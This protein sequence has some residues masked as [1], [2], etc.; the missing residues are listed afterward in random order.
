MPLLPVRAVSERRKRRSTLPALRSQSSSSCVPAQH[1]A[2]HV[3]SRCCSVGSVVSNAMTA[4]WRISSIFFA[5]FFLC[6]ISTG[7]GQT[8]EGREL[9]QATLLADVTAVVPGKPFTVGARLRMVPNWHTYW[10]F[11]G[12]AGIPTEIKWK[13]PDGWKAGQIQWPVPLRLVEPGDIQIYGYH[14]EV[15]LLQEITPPP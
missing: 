8:Y 1:T 2:S 9:V 6:A 12:D 7:H 10:E 11:P 14:D 4:R 13:L 5:A 3:P 15:L